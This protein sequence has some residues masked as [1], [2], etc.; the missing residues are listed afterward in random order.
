MFTIEINGNEYELSFGMGFVREINKRVVIKQENGVEAK[1][2]LS[3]AIAGIIDGDIEQLAQVLIAAANGKLK[4]KDIDEHLENPDTD[5]DALFDTVMDFFKRSNC[6][7]RQTKKL[8]EI[9]EN[10]K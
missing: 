9:V 4:M 7:G 5:I 1:Q 8:L 10:Q 3:Y 6:T 2:G